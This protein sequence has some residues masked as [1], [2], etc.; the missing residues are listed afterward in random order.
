[1][2]LRAVE[3]TN[4]TTPFWARQRSL[5]CDGDGVREECGDDGSTMITICDSGGGVVMSEV[6]GGRCVVEAMGEWRW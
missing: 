5:E 4:A 1:M 2:H 3:I 6:K